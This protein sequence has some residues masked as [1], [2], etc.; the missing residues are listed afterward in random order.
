M[1]VL[2]ARDI[3]LSPRRASS[4]KGENGRVLVVG[5]S[6]DYPGSPALLGL[7]A[8]SA[9]RGGSDLVTVAAPAKVAWAVNCAAP[10]LITRKLACT[11]WS[12][13]Q[14]PAVLE[15]ARTADVVAIGNGITL[16][17]ASAAFIRALVRKLASLKKPVVL[18]AAALRTV[19]I[20]DCRHAVLTPHANEYAHLLRNSALVGAG[21]PDVQRHLNDTVLLLKKGHCVIL[22]HARAAE[23]RTGTAGM[24]KGGMGD[25][26]AGLT[27]GLIA[28][29]ND[30]FTAACAAAYVNGK[31]GEF[32][33][34]EQGFG[35]TASDLALSLPRVLKRFQRIA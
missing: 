33:T 9:L 22:D 35:F 10:D 21:Y 29:G 8:L 6:E 26:L 14:V 27:A 5:G 11:A 24:T 23:T 17:P 32:L 16:A 1:K 19:R 4:H 12:Q 3:H 2:S 28:Q 34:R 25:V 7:A 20:Q 18:D 31:A 13:K 30:Q 15:L